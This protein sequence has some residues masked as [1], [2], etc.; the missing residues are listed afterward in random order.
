MQ[1]LKSTFMLATLI[2]FVSSCGSIKN[3]KSTSNNLAEDRKYSRSEIKVNTDS[4]SMEAAGLNTVYF[5]FNSANLRNSARNALERNSNFLR[6]HPNV[7]IQVEGHC[8]ERGSV[9]YNLALGERRSQSVKDYLVATGVNPNRITTISFGKERPLALGH[10]EMSWSK[11]R[12]GNFVII[13][14]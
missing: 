2:L 8:D 7:R 10:D 9:Q 14:K 1:S 11:N 3:K 5:P 4:D 12:R 13:G 6:N